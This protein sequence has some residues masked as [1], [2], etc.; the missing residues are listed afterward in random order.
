MTN[1]SLKLEEH[2]LSLESRQDAASEKTSSPHSFLAE[3]ER[4]EILTK[5]PQPRIKS[6][7]D[8]QALF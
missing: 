3:I 7:A 6:F 1:S 4:M 8:S 5:Q 2:R